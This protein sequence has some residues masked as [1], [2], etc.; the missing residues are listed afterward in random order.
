MRCKLRGCTVSIPWTCEAA[1]YARTK[2]RYR[3]PNIETATR[4]QIVALRMETTPLEGAKEFSINKIVPVKK[5]SRH[6]FS[7]TF[8]SASQGRLT[9][10]PYA[11]SRPRD[12][13]SPPNCCNIVGIIVARAKTIHVLSTTPTSSGSFALVLLASVLKS[14]WQLPAAGC[15]LLHCCDEQTNAAD[16][17]KD[18]PPPATDKTFIYRL[19]TILRFHNGLSCFQQYYVVSYHGTSYYQIR[20]NDVWLTLPQLRSSATAIVGCA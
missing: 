20:I 9:Q 16:R 6:C 10:S 17:R 11:P 7:A 1:K 19:Y 4:T 14:F 2:S 15:R 18:E 8:T 13:R 3:I 5:K 12:P